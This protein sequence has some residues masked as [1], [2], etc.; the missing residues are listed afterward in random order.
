MLSTM[1]GVATER[2]QSQR[3]FDL[4]YA[5]GGF[6]SA[7]HKSFRSVVGPSSCLRPLQTR[8]GD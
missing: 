8:N 6:T 3:Q 4:A 7:P 5:G 1:T 2:L